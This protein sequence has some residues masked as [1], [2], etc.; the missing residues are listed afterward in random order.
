[1]SIKQTEIGTIHSLEDFMYFFYCQLKELLL[2]TRY[3]Q[4]ILNFAS[5]LALK[6]DE[7][8]ICI[9]KYKFLVFINCDKTNIRNENWI[10]KRELNAINVTSDS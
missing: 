8:A 6:P 10:E 1:M 4:Q 3:I 5:L 7:F 2:L 9:E